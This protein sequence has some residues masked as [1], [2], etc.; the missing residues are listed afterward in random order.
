[1]HARE[2]I[3]VVEQGADLDR[4]TVLREPANDVRPKLLG[5]M[6]VG[7]GPGRGEFEDAVA[8]VEYQPP[9]RR[10]A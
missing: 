9:R 1:M 6:F 10:V 5:P 8:V 3:I 4:D 2:R 7:T